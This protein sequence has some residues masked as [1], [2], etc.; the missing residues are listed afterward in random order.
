MIGLQSCGALETRIARGAHHFGVADSDPGH[1]TAMATQNNQSGWGR[2][3]KRTIVP[4][5]ARVMASLRFGTR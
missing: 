2:R 3:C 5:T 4:V 1:T